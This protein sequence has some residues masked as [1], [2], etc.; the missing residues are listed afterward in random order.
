[1]NFESLYKFVCESGRTHEVTHAFKIKEFYIWE[2]VVNSLFEEARTIIDKITQAQKRL[3]EE[4]GANNMPG[5]L[6]FMASSIKSI[7]TIQHKLYNAT[8][9]ELLPVLERD[10]NVELFHR[11]QEYHNFHKRVQN[12]QEIN[13]TLK[14]IITNR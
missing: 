13:E 4:G 6:T 1:M 7:N 5:Y 9:K 2:D 12:L 3:K 8:T 10:G 11:S 14:K